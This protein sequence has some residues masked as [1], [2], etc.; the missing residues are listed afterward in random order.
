MDFKKKKQQTSKQTKINEEID[1]VYPQISWTEILLSLLF[2]H[3]NLGG[4]W[5]GHTEEVQPKESIKENDRIIKF[6]KHLQVH[7]IQPLIHSHH[8]H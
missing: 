7:K 5:A 8:A 1:K 2:L 4:S 6:G 3:A